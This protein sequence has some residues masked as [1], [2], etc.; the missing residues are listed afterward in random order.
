[1]LAACKR[2]HS[3]FRPT[4]AAV[5]IKPSSNI[6]VKLCR[7]RLA[8]NSFLL[9]VARLFETVMSAVS[10][11]QPKYE[12]SYLFG[13]DQSLQKSVLALLGQAKSLMISSRQSFS[14]QNPYPFFS[15]DSLEAPP[16]SRHPITRPWEKEI[17]HP[18]ARRLCISSAG[19]FEL[20]SD[21]TLNFYGTVSVLHQLY[22][23]LISSRYGY[24]FL[25]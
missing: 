23:W 9:C 1:M 7:I 5:R 11:A 12:R 6:F 22:L 19:K 16:S 3:R 10:D 17:N 14:Y 13:S 18:G 15:S 24:R 20:P 25:F 2:F 21:V 8:E 4:S